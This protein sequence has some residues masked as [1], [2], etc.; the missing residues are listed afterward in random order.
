MKNKININNVQVSKPTGESVLT[1]PTLSI[2]ENDI[3]YIY[4]KNGSG[5][6]TF[7][8]FIANRLPLG[9]TITAA[10]PNQLI[11]AEF[12]TSQKSLSLL[13][14]DIIQDNDYA[15]KTIYCDSNKAAGRLN[16]F[17][18][19]KIKEIFNPYSYEGL[20]FKYLYDANRNF[21]TDFERYQDEKSS[22]KQFSNI[23]LI[24]RFLILMMNNDK[25]SSFGQHYDLI[26]SKILN[27]RFFQLSSGQKTITLLFQQ[28]IL[29]HLIN[30]VEKTHKGSPF[31]ELTEVLVFDEPLAALDLINKRLITQELELL[32]RTKFISKPI[33][34][35]VSHDHQFDFISPKLPQEYSDRQIRILQ[36]ESTRQGHQIIEIDT[37]K[38]NHIIKGDLR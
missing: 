27:R 19:Q 38:L 22:D 11:Q 10:M 20:S 37:I 3:V 1:I 4:G 31:F 36:I 15:K 28:L 26:A 9:L 16:V 6:S 17:V 5:K 25:K 29:I 2:Y 32:C 30:I 7:L 12:Q 18:F 24:N 23:P 35:I 34:F 13:R 33:I 14:K 8:K 21:Q